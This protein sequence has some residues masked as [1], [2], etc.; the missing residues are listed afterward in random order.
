MYVGS[1]STLSEI[2]S[3]KKCKLEGKSRSHRLPQKLKLTIFE[4]FSSSKKIARIIASEVKIV[5]QLVY[6]QIFCCTNFPFFTA[7]CH[8]L[9]LPS[10]VNRTEGLMYQNILNE[11]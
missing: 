5:Q 2:N 3:E 1:S 4:F 10:A 8:I 6:P 9:I 7:H 11:K